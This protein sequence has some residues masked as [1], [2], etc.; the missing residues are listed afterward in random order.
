V[1]DAN[2]RLRKELELLRVERAQQERQLTALR[3]EVERM[4]HTLL[5]G[6]EPLHHTTS[7]AA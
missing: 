1:D 4:A 6:G 3:D 5:E 2:V 7:R